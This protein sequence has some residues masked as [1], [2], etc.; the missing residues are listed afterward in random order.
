[1]LLWGLGGGIAYDPSAD[2]WRRMAEA[3]FTREFATATW[4]GTELL[5]WGGAT[6]EDCV[7][8]CPRAD[9]LAYRPGPG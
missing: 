8:G 7:D 5:V 2:R 3:P 6:G 9:G 1:M 4:T